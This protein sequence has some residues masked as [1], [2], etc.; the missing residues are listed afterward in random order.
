ML[1]RFPLNSFHTGLKLGRFGVAGDDDV[2]KIGRHAKIEN[3]LVSIL[4]KL[5]AK[6]IAL[7]WSWT[8]RDKQCQ[9]T[10]AEGGRA[11]GFAPWGLILDCFTRISISRVPDQSLN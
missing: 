11:H 6:P 9:K 10:N 4:V 5:A 7:R 2:G 8:G 3:I 1:F